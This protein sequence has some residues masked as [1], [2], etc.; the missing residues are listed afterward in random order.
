MFAGRYVSLLLG[1]GWTGE[2]TAPAGVFKFS[3]FCK[4]P[5]NDGESFL[6]GAGS[7]PK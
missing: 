4:A 3:K 7:P 5:A 2:K 6:R 1:E